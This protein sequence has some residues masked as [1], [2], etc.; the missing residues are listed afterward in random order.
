MEKILV[1]HLNDRVLAPYA[2]KNFILSQLLDS[3]SAQKDREMQAYIFD[4]DVQIVPIPPGFTVRYSHVVF[5]LCMCL[6]FE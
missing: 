3:N 6:V 4:I 1:K 5:N 2:N